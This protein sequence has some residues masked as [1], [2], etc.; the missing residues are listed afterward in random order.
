MPVV[1]GLW[2]NENTS[3]KRTRRGFLVKDLCSPSRAMV[4]EF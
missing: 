2:L 3:L 1:S 4:N